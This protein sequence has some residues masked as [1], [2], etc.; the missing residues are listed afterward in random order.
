MMAPSGADRWVRRSRCAEPLRRPEQEKFLDSWRE[1]WRDRL[2]DAFVQP[3]S[4][5]LERYESIAL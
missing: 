2:A 3:N 1:V 4:P 5:G